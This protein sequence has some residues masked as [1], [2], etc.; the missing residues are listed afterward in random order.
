MLETKLDNHTCTTIIRDTNGPVEGN[1][2]IYKSRVQDWLFLAQTM[3]S[4]LLRF[5]HCIEQINVLI[6][7][8]GPGLVS[9]PLPE[10]FCVC[11][12]RLVTSH[13]KCQNLS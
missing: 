3:W 12:P 8:V 10:V 9:R 7:V 5:H 4:S 13:S 2:A 1:A 11:E 6:F